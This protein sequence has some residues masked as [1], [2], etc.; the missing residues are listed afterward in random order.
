MCLDTY[1]VYADAFFLQ[2]LDHGD[3]AIQMGWPPY[4]EVIVVKF[5]VRGISV[6]EYKGVAHHLVTV[7]VKGFDPSLVSV[8][9]EFSDDF[10]DYIPSVDLSGI[11]TGNRLDVASHGFYEFFPGLW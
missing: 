6:C 10:I 5:R 1:S 3:D 4:I 8:F 2:F 7:T 11:T 9:S